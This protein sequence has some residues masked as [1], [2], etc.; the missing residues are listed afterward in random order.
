MFAVKAEVSDPIPRTLA[1]RAQKTMYG[2]KHVA[3]HLGRR[4]QTVIHGTWF[5]VEPATPEPSLHIRRRTTTPAW[6]ERDTRHYNGGGR[7]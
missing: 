3:G 6:C 1:F 2:G 4:R 7:R 5:A